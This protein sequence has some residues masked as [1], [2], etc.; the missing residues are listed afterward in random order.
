MP[1][2][3]RPKQAGYNKRGYA[4]NNK[5]PPAAWFDPPMKALFVDGYHNDKD[6]L[7]LQHAPQKMIDS[8]KS[9]NKK[10]TDELGTQWFN[11]GDPALGTVGVFSKFMCLT[12]KDTKPVDDLFPHGFISK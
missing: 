10:L 1:Y 11:Q 3:N 2:Q 7:A 6:R 12:K 4:K 8:W 5:A 9:K